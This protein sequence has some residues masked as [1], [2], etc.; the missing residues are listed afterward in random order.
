MQEG[1]PIFLAAIAAA[2]ARK[3]LFGWIHNVPTPEEYGGWRRLAVPLFYRRAKKLICNSVATKDS[4]RAAAG[5]LGGRW[6]VANLPVNVDSIRRQA[7]E[8]LPAW[9]VEAFGKKVV[10]GI[11]RF[12][13]VKR[14]DMLIRIA[15]LLKA[16]REDFHVVILGRG[17]LRPYLD[18]LCLELDVSDVVTICDYDPNPFRYIGHSRVVVIPSEIEPFGLV[19]IEAMA[20]GKVPI[21]TEKY[22]AFKE[23][24]GDESELGIV[25]ADSVVSL[26]VAVDRE[27]SNEEDTRLSDRRMRRAEDFDVRRCTE[28]MLAVLSGVLTHAEAT[29]PES[30]TVP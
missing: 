4:W 16:K 15:A 28:A 6:T 1:M 27:L 23:I 29:V 24:V 5:D 8:P 12:V 3:P 30:T 17:P 18:A 21:C 20:L 13:P 9:I 10:I 26:A 22:E 19:A 14:M 25:T 2:M 11:G 7:L